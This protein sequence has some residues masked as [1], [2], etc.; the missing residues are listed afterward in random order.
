MPF[1]TCVFSLALM[2]GAAHAAT[3]QSAPWR[4][5]Q[6]PLK[7]RVHALVSR[8]TLAQKV[9]QMMNQA[10]AIP[11]LGVPA[12]N[13]WSEGLHGIA[14]S[15][16]ATVFPQAIGMA[17]TFDPDAVGQMADIIST[18][19][20]AKHSWALRHGIHSIYYGLTLWAPNINIVRDP[21][22]GRG[23]ETYGE[24]PFLTATY[25]VRY[26]KGLQ[27]DNP[28]YLKTVATPKHFAVYNGPEPLRHKINVVASA[29][30]LEATYYPA[31]RAAI[32]DA[33]A[34]SMM[35]SY[36][37]IDGVPS[38]ANRKLAQ[39]V[40]GDWGFKGFI[41]SDCGAI[42]D[43][44]RKDGHGY[45]SDEAHAAAAGVKAGT[46]TDCG[47]AYK[48]LIKAV[49]EG[50]VS[51][52][53][54][55]QAVERLFTARF[56]LG[57]F[58]PDSKVAYARIPFSE[59]NSPAHH[60]AA[61]DA[62]RKAM[63][64]LKN[65][66]DVLPLK[67]GQTIAVV[68]PNAAELSALEGNYNAVPS[69]PVMPVDGIAEAFPASRVLYAQG[70]SYDARLSVPMPRSQFRIEQGSAQQGLTARYYDNA[71]FKG[72]PVLTRVDKQINFDWNA[73]SPAKGVPANHFSVAWTGTVQVPAAGDY[74]LQ[75]TLAHCYPCHD[76]EVFRMWVDGKEVTHATTKAADASRDVRMPA[77]T[78]H[79]ADT[80][81]H[82][83]RITYTHRSKLFG[84]GLT[85]NWYPPQAALRKQ[86]VATASKADVVVAV[87]GLSPDFVGEEMPIKVPGF[88]GGDRTRLS[89]P[90]SQQKL[91]HALAATG[92]PVV[93]VLM[94]GSAL[95][96]DWAEQ[97]AAAMVEAWYP[98]EAG[99]QAIGETLSGANNP[100]GKLPITFY[101]SVK[102]LPPFT[103]YSMAHRTYRYFTG[104]PL[105]PFGF[106]LSYTTF[107]FSHVRVSSATLQA[108][109]PL[110]VQADVRNTGK[111]AGDAVAEL[112]LVPP[113]A[114]LN[115]RHALRG[116]QRVHLAPGQTR[117]LV[118]KLDPRQLSLVDAKGQRAVMP[119]SYRIFIGGSQ[120]T[121]VSAQSAT[122]T[123]QGRQALPK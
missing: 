76:R 73:A 45:S 114:G 84:A 16:Y 52:A 106:G 102:Q 12:Y 81:P 8:M 29:H 70:A 6:L 20:R 22:W 109:Q 111:R 11:S 64:L 101:R 104:K 71:Q 50:L 78:V 35:C 108:G 87:M 88:K 99:G 62:A 58:D 122:L 79:F 1:G 18:E 83:V 113:Q 53:D 97:H 7:Q 72:K 28:N 91:L 69:A 4:N 42:S 36:N 27:G 118:F 13:W 3:T 85:L 2:G 120:P 115:P 31:F 77:F 37:A 40:R 41:T 5:T 61:L 60:Q 67:N 74:R 123:I 30:D 38:C 93:L 25:A 90:A 110:T 26:V 10:P 15:G 75:P 96:V 68:G 103:D 116:L 55:N 105:F 94:N 23:Q 117:H 89:L 107:D 59:V 51:E 9:G 47:D 57:M 14:R 46:D 63:V 82:T 112:Y 92:K 98:G 32:V 43:F 17:A 48:G 44:Y 49:H 65:K 66:D 19:A 39:V 80:H 33:H 86:A 24:D 100:G 34:D 119:G 21:R 95:A 56:R 54:I 121:A